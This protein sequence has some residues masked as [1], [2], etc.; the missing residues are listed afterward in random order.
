[1]LK[2][3]IISVTCALF[4]L[5]GSSFADSTDTHSDRAGSYHFQASLEDGSSSLRS[6]QLTWPI[7]SNLLQKD[8]RDLQVYNADKQAV[9]FTIRSVAADKQVHQQIRKLNFFPMEDIEKLGILLKQEANEKGYKAVKLMQI[10]QRYLIID[11]PKPDSDKRPLPLQQLTLNWNALDH[12]LPK[13]LRVEASDDLTRWQPL[14]IEK[15]PYRM[16][17]NGVVLENHDLRFKQSTQKRFIRLSGSEDFEPVLKALN[18]VSGH[19]YQSHVNHQPLNWSAVALEASDTARQY[20][21]D[22]PPSVSIKRW[23]LE[24]LAPDNLY[25]GRL[26]T[27]SAQRAGQKEPDWQL[28]QNFMQYSIRT[29]DGLVTSEASQVVNRKWSREWRIDLMQDF[30]TDNLPKLELAWEP[31]ELVFVAQGDG[32]FEIRYGSRSNQ[33]NTRMNL[34]K[35]L[36]EA[37]PEAVEIGTITQLSKVT[38]SDEGAQ[39]KYLLWGLLAA[40]VL[41]LLYMAKGLFRE[42]SS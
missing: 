4:S 2:P 8:L 31:L 33:A 18:D 28:R 41:M 7:V 25:K 17:E 36:A 3:I 34:A 26:Y 42:M 15:L 39:Y 38:E 19:Y 27:R 10:G 30:T 37:T 29:E 20:R 32:P 24:S 13:S 22:L 12:W 11:N 23:R 14:A 6:V 5:I 21:Y 16:A 40:A 9:P 35:L 1:M